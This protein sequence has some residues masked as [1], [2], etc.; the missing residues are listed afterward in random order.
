MLR[1]RAKICKLESRFTIDDYCCV[2]LDTF[3]YKS[4][5]SLKCCNNYL[6]TDCLLQLFI[7]SKTDCPLCRE[8]IPVSFFFRIFPCQFCYNFV[9]NYTIFFLKIM[10]CNFIISFLII[11]LLEYKKIL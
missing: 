9:K 8:K 3:A 10:L 2:C 5:I 11:N 4:F 6:H 1:M 7:N